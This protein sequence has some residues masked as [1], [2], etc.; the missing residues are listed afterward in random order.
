M[1]EPVY[2][3]KWERLPDM[4]CGKWEPASIAIDDKLYVHGG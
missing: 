1:S 2:E 4:P 3:V